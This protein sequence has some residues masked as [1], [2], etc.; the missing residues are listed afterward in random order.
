VDIPGMSTYLVL[1]GNCIFGFSTVR[2]IYLCKILNK[3]VKIKTPLSFNNQV[4]CW[5]F[6]TF[7]LIFRYK[8]DNLTYIVSCC[9]WSVQRQQTEKNKA[10]NRTYLV[11]AD[12][13]L[14]KYFRNLI[15]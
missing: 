15:R 14:C 12:Y 8:L 3:N 13:W 7:V 5:I 4:C 1:A 11:F 9:L 2:T 10:D 6:H